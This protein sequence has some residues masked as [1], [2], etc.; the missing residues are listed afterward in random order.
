MTKTATSKSLRLGIIAHPVAHSLSPILYRA[1]CAAVGLEFGGGSSGDSRGVSF[2]LFDVLPEKLSAFFQRMRDGEIDG[3]AVSVPHK[4]AVIPLLDIVDLRAREIG[5]VNTVRV[6]CADGANNAR[7]G[8]RKI[9]LEGYN[10]DWLG[11]QYA[12][13]DALIHSGKK[14]TTWKW[15]NAFVIGA[16]GAA[17]AVACAL[18][19]EGAHIF[20]MNRTRERAEEMAKKFGGSVVTLGGE[21]GNIPSTFDL[22]VNATSVGLESD[23][24]PLPISFWEEHGNGVAF[25]CVYRGAKNAGRSG[26]RGH[27]GALTRFLREADRAGW[28]MVSGETML[29]GQAVEQFFLL[30][31]ERVEASVFARAL[32][33]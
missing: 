22:V 10:T 29:I 20:F 5:A 23:E 6:R 18:R 31:G 17:K 1:G 13:R 21:A 30:T 33:E 32:S 3:V 2:E 4:E 15:K 11:V 8:A 9:T 24:S 27:I 25:D 16:G 28:A 7:G 19:E 26:D 14:I 12:L